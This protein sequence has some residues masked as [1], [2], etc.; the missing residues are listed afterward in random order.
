MTNLSD[1]LLNPTLKDVLE[2]FC[3]DKNIPLARAAI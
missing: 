2:T 1:E 3:L